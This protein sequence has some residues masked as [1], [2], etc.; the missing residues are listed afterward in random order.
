MLAVLTS[1]GG[2][3][4]CLA[5]LGFLTNSNNDSE[6]LGVGSMGGSFDTRAVILII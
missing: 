2:Y 6:G 4:N 5:K 1:H 3:I